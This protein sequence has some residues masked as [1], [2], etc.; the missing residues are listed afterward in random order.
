M[1]LRLLFE[2]HVR[3]RKTRN[4]N[5][6]FQ[7]SWN[8]CQDVGQADYAYSHWKRNSE[9]LLRIANFGVNLLL[10]RVDT[11]DYLT[12]TDNVKLADLECCCT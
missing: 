12:T 2:T 3:C 5:V 7:G 8:V 10:A 6:G 9:S 4:S 1:S 11:S